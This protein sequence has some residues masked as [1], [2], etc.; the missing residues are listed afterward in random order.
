MRKF[1]H[2]NLLKLFEVYETDN[3]IYMV[4]ELLKGGN[5][6]EKVLKRIPFSL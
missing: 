5:L 3:S 2:V 4:L 6:L 1:N